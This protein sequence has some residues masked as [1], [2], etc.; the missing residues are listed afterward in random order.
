MAHKK[1]S[2]QYGAH[3]VVLETGEIARQASAAVMVSMG[4]TVVLVTVVGKKEDS[5]RDF[6]PLNVIFFIRYSF[7]LT[8]Y[9]IKSNSVKF[10]WQK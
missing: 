5:G 7:S 6:F 4:E 1:K 3:T 10:P 2:F 8:Q 9:C